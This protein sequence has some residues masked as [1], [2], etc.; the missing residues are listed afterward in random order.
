MPLALA[1]IY[2][3]RHVQQDTGSMKH[4]LGAR[5]VR[6]CAMENVRWTQARALIV[7]QDTGSMEHGLD[8]RHARMYAM[9]NVMWTQ[10]RALIVPQDTGSMKCGRGVNSVIAPG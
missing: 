10:A 3:V 9:E 6:V 1:L 8:A 7:P 2:F 4:G 5:R